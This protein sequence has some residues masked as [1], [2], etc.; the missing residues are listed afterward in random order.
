MQPR[1]S[2]GPILFNWKADKWR[3]FY[4]QV[5]DEMPV[6]IVYIGEVICSKRS[7]FFEPHYDEIASRLTRAGK[8]VVFS[9]LAEIMIKRE[10]RMTE[11]MCSLEE[12]AVEANDTAALFHL[13]GKP[14]F[15]GQYLNTYNEQTMQHFANH[16]AV[17][18]TLPVE[19]PA[20]TIKILTAKAIELGVGCEV[21]VYGR[22]P[23][24]LSARCYHARAHHRIKDNCQFVCENDPDGMVLKTVD[25]K[26]FLAVN[27]VQTMSYSY[28]NLIQEIPRMME[29]GVSHFRISPHSENMLVITR[30]FQQVVNRE[31]NPTQAVNRIEESCGPMPF[32]NGFFHHKPG[33]RWLEA[34]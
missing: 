6:D 24:A 8:K 11:S 9:T 16:G 1:L 31:I 20:E 2:L 14:H 4:Y 17:H 34:S 10:R 13:R 28:L 21:M 22:I 12:F 29:W 33:Y 25:G 7:P 15:A 3:D 30:I 23:L 27:G 32:S 26:P 5:A 18:F 19:L